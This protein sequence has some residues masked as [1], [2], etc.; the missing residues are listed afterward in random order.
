MPI[1]A[2]LKAIQEAIEEKARAFGLDFYQIFYE[3]LSPREINEMAA[4]TGFPQ[5]YPHWR[6]GMS[7]DQLEKGYAYGGQRIYEMVINNDPCYAYL[8]S[9]NST[10]IQKMVMAHVCAHC[11]FFKNNRYF[12]ATNRK[13]I[14]EMANH[15]ARVRRYIDRYGEDEVESF[16]DKALSLENLID[17]NLIF[18]G[19]E[20]L[21]KLVKNGGAEA[22]NSQPEA[23]RKF[24]VPSY[25]D[26]FVNPPEAL[27]AEAKRRKEAAAL[28]KK[29]FP[30]VPVRDVLWFL[31][32]FSPADNWKKDIL[33]I[34]REEA[35]YF[36][37]QGMTKILNEGWAAFWHA[38][39]CTSGALND[40]EIVEFADK[41]ADVLAASPTSINPYR[42]GLQLLRDVEERWNK[43]RHGR[44]FDEIE[45]MTARRE[46][47]AKEMKGLEKIFEIRKTH[48]DVSFIDEYMTK[49]FVEKVLL[50]NYRLDRS[51]GEY[52]ISSRDYKEIKD[53]ILGGLTNMGQPVIYVIDGNFENK[54]EL[55]LLHDHQ[56]TD[57]H[58]QHARATLAN[59]F[60]VWTRP[61][62]IATLINERGTL[63]KFDGKSHST[64]EADYKNFKFK[65]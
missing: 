37:P 57:L 36:A 30:H 31:I 35:Y 16:L 19:E 13:M 40:S 58:V 20:K 46:Y 63:M 51:K 27:A 7:F 22:E 49:E 6:F 32:Q 11:D 3:M 54:G 59:L 48:N 34:V 9:T 60:D 14:D 39:L 12:S 53:K 55:L 42:L 17:I 1:S 21:D 47:D 62:S 24:D 43:G 65:S 41:N 64:R 56:G 2:E 29:R 10:T 23:P 8:M 50:Y 52:V 45:D 5:R 61:V 33:S 15:S 28:Q 4:F 38:K 18:Y 26:K 44:K 25:M